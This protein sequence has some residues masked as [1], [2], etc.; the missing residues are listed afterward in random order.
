MV[1]FLDNSSLKMFCG[2]AKSE[3][4]W[5]AGVRHIVAANLQ[6]V[7]CFRALSSLPN[8]IFKG[9]FQ[10]RK[11]KFIII[12]S[13]KRSVDWKKSLCAKPKP[14]SVSLWIRKH[15]I[16]SVRW[17]F[18]MKQWFVGWFIDGHFKA[19]DFEDFVCLMQRRRFQDFSS[20]LCQAIL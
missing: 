12:E 20:A 6:F 3:F 4:Y 13:I 1:A 11:I 5:I 9:K 15:F 14:D 7:L 8:D 19:N 2:E 18:G 17:H 10:R 16:S